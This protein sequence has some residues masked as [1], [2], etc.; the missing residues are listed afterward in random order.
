MNP[1]Q[2]LDKL[3]QMADSAAP[4]WT[5]YVV[6]LL[7]LGAAVGAVWTAHPLAFVACGLLALLAWSISDSAPHLRRAAQAATHGRQRDG[8]V[9]VEVTTWT[10]SRTCEAVVADGARSWRFEFAPMGWEP[11]EGRFPARLYTM[12]DVEWPVLAR[13]EAGLLV[14]R[15]QPRV[16]KTMGRSS[17]D[18]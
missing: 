8:W 11:R 16:E 5:L 13:I 3:L 2:Q 18:D 9:R 12:P 6:L 4:T 15:R 17:G 7:T 10:E 14:P 1:E